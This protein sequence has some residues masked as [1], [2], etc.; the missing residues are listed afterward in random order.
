MKHTHTHNVITYLQIH[1]K[2]FP[3]T[4]RCISESYM[5]MYMWATVDWDV[6]M[7]NAAAVKR[8]CRNELRANL[9]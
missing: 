7:E 3:W 8:K 9:L 6:N 4:V 2:G 5:C 1:I